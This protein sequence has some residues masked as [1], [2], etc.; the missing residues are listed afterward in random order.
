VKL[1]DCH[2]HGNR[3]PPGSIYIGRRMPGIEA[4]P[5]ANPYVPKS[6]A[7]KPC[8]WAVTVPDRSVLERY[9]RRLT[10]SVVEGAYREQ[11][12]GPAFV[13]LHRL[14][15]R[16][17]LACWCASREAAL[18][19]P[20]SPHVEKPCHGD[21]VATLWRTLEDRGWDMPWVI[22]DQ[23]VIRGVEVRGRA[24]LPFEV[25]DRTRAKL[26]ELAFGEPLTWGS[27]V[28]AETEAHR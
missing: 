26:Y 10:Q 11:H 22:W 5:L 12:G 13:E 15:S 3:P 14:T 23:P 6:T 1:V 27:R 8:L 25:V 17:T 7:P 18:V 9:R 16:A 24:L 21:I 19:G 28:S 2:E 4:S 20:A